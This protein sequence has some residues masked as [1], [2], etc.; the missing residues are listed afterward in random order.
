MAVRGA[1]DAVTKSSELYLA[2][3]VDYG[4]VYILQTQLLIQQDELTQA[5]GQIASNLVDL[6]KALGGGWECSCE[7]GPTWQVDSPSLAAQ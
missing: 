5:R 4:R 3:S 2:G 1:E 6:F 7:A